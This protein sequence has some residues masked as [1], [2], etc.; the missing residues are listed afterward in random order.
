MYVYVLI[1]EGGRGPASGEIVRSNIAAEICIVC[2]YV[3]WLT[4]P[5]P[6]PKR[7]APHVSCNTRA[8]RGRRGYRQASSDAVDM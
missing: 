1:L 7:P 8:P 4:G 2:N 6:P 3:D 5:P